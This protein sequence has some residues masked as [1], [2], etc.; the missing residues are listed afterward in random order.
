MGAASCRASSMTTL[1][2]NF[3][4]SLHLIKKARRNLPG[5]R[6]TADVHLAKVRWLS[7]RD[8]PGMKSRAKRCTQDRSPN[9]EPDFSDDEIPLKNGNGPRCLEGAAAPTGPRSRIRLH[10]RKSRTGEWRGA[11]LGSLPTAAS[12]TRLSESDHPA[13]L[14]EVDGDSKPAAQGNRRFGNRSQE[15]SVC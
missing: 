4:R 9:T 13:R 15:A 2:T 5:R 10:T 7:W 6:S 3:T 12:A 8:A 1:K 11:P 14:S